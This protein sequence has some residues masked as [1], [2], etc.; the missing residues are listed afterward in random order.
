MI[1][2]NVTKF[3]FRAE[4][5]ADA[6]VVRAVL[7]SWILDWKEV[8]SNLEHE[9]VIHAMPDVDVEFTI[10]DEGPTLGEILWLLDCIGNC[11]VAAETLAF[12]EDYTG[13]RSSRDPLAAPAQL[14]RK[15]ILSQ[16]LSAVRSRQALLNFEH[17]RA[18][19]LH[20]TY[21]TAFRRGEKWKDLLAV[22]TT[23]GWIATAQH[24]ATGL[25]AIRRICAP[26]GCKNSQK[27]QN[28]CVTSRMA[29][30]VA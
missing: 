30:I 7:L 6:Q 23:P 21:D 8:R 22:E 28:K 1:I 2:D 20:R 26:F 19:Q 17:E 4:C 25:T 15:E 9:G 27:I 3:K 11:H 12:A 24:A 13:E 14:P 29:T 10:V 18:L 5:T 16:V